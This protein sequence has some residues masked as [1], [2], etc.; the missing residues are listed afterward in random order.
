MLPGHDRAEVP[1]LAAASVHHLPLIDAFVVDVPAGQDP[2]RWLAGVRNHP[3]VEYAVVDTKRASLAQE[4]PNDPYFDRQWGLANT[5][6]LVP[7]GEAGEQAGRAGLDVG[8]RGAWR[9]GTASA[10]TMIAVL[11]TGIDITHPDLQGAIWTNPREV[12]GNRLDDD[13]NG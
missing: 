10:R 6:Q 2:H 12:P 1:Q 4:A 7:Y 13:G 8:A 9:L 5:G 3:A 11:D